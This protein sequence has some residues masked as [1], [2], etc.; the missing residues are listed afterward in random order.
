MGY[1]LP[2]IMSR[3]EDTERDKFTKIENSYNL[4]NIDPTAAIYGSSLANK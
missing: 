3:L 1:F 4:L 2:N